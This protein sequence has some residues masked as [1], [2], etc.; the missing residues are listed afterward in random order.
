[1]KILIPLIL[2]LLGVVVIIAEVIIPSA[3]ML[4]IVAALLLIY[5]LFLVF[6]SISMAAGYLMV[7]A[8]IFII[9]AAIFFGI[10]LLAISPA[11]LNKNLSS[12]D[13]VTAQSPEMS[14]LVGQKGHALSDLRPSGTAAIGGKRLDVVTRGEYLEKTSNLIVLSVTGNQII[15]GK[16]ADNNPV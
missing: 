10:K 6:T 15:V 9:P 16:Q 3:G 13:G 11:T 8:D 7:A 4:A 14:D 5:S 12:K 2:Q 1:M